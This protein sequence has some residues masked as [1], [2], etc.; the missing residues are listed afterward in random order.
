MDFKN[1]PFFITVT[2]K[3]T[4]QFFK[5]FLIDGLDK[6]SVIQTIISVCNID[7][8]SF[9]ISAEEAPIDQANSW[10]DDKFP[11]G[12]SKHNVIDEEQRIVELIYNPMGNPYG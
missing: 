1:K 7:P 6:D 12:Q 9:N 4:G 5:E 3:F 2:N 8:L 11:S 10:I